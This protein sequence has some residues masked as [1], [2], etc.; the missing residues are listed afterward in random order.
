[1]ISVTMVT[2]SL[3][4]RKSLHKAGA[5]QIRKSQVDWVAGLSKL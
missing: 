1:M 3:P 5:A 4:V 2:D